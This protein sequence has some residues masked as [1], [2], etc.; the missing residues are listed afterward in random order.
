MI[1]IARKHQN[2]EENE[3]EVW[4]V[5]NFQQHH[6]LS[7]DRKDV[8][9]PS[10]KI[11]TKFLWSLTK[12][13]S[14]SRVT[15]GNKG[16]WKNGR[17]SPRLWSKKNIR[18]G[19]RCGADPLLWYDF[20]NSSIFSV[21]GV[22]VGVLVAM[23]SV[24]RFKALLFAG[25]YVETFVSCLWHFHSSHRIDES[26]QVKPYQLVLLSRWWSHSGQVAAYLTSKYR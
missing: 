12:L 4:K 5:S 9:L 15:S 11:Y 22:I 24:S 16:I 8:C 19:S 3:K 2:I 6:R 20:L 1:H 17:R 25:F 10:V 7:P 26:Q 14:V 23:V 21:F 18:V 13:I